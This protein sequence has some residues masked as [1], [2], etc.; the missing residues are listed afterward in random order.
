MGIGRDF[1]TLL[2]FFERL[3]LFVFSSFETG[4]VSCFFNPPNFVT[5][6]QAMDGIA[7]K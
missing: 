2:Q 6:D 4:L 5:K 7:G 1:W 3:Y